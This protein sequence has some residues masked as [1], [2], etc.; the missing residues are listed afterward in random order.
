MIIYE[1]PSQLDGKPIVGIITGIYKKSKN[2]KTG[3]M[4]Q[5]WI[6]RSD[7]HPLDCLKSKEDYSICGDCKH[8]PNDLGVRTCYVNL[9][10]LG[11]IFKKYKVGGYSGIVDSY[12]ELLYNKPQVGIRLGAY[13][14]PSA[15]PFYVIKELD[16]LFLF[17][18]G[19][20][21][22]WKNPNFDT[23]KKYVMASCDSKE[24]VEIARDRGWSTFNVRKLGELKSK[25]E[26]QCQGQAKTTCE[27]CKLCNGNQERQRHIS[28]EVHGRNA[29]KF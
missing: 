10:P 4:A 13:G 8:R 1:G 5:L 21:H 20:T 16:K 15:L 14:D 24:E 18:T 19:Y 3:Q 22:Q 6:I 23:L 25:E 2:P 28:I 29:K 7:L 11:K 26:I 9:M 27:L 17:S 12:L